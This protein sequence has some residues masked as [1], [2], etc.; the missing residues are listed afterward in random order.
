MK[1]FTKRK[2]A[3]Y[4]NIIVVIVAFLISVWPKAATV[5]IYIPK[6]WRP[7]VGFSLIWLSISILAGKY[8][9]N[10]KEKFIS[11]W[12]KIFRADIYATSF[13]LIL[14]YLFN[15]FHYSRLIVFGTIGL[16][17][18][19]ES[20]FLAFFYYSNKLKKYSDISSYLTAPASEFAESTEVIDKQIIQLPSTDAA[21]VLQKLK[22]VYL[23]ENLTLFEFTKNNTQIER[24]PASQTLALHT[25]H[26]YNIKHIDPSSLLLFVNLHEVNGWSRINEYLRQVNHDLKKGGFF[27]SCGEDYRRRH[28]RYTKNYPALLA[29]IATITDF[30]FRRVIQKIPVIREIYFALFQEAHKPFSQSEILG[31]VAYFG[32]DIIDVMEKDNLFYFVAQKFTDP[33][34]EDNPVYGP[35]IKMKRIGK[36]GKPIYIYKFRTMFPYAEYLQEFI[37]LKNK[38][39]KGG[40]IKDDFRIIPCGKLLRRLW[41]DELP[42][43]WNLIRGDIKLVGVR[44]ISKHYFSLYP[45][46]A[47]KLRKKVKPGLIPPFYVD[48]P[49]SFKEIINSETIYIE[50]YL[51]KPLL[52][53]LKYLLKALYNILFHHARSA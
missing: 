9:Y 52:T 31:R 18:I 33:P 7:F 17:F 19:G 38:L 13:I 53:D 26:I 15:V 51:K 24:I 27:V 6:Y 29:W 5:R 43:F 36:N 41:I 32:F 49:Y 25:H 14:L 11:N 3:F 12:L 35:L 4:L 30:I 2:I 39:K 42:Q 45:K 48:M 47:Q 20:L 44:A 37:F 22:Q 23:K 10:L 16:S 1:L 34:F 21:S 40:K 46:E 50:Q 28:L 8:N